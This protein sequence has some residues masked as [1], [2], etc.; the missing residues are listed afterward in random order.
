ML[1]KI[2]DFKKH[3]KEIYDSW[4]GVV[5]ETTRKNRK[6][7]S[8]TIIL[9]PPNITGFLH[10]G[11]AFTSTIQDILLR[12]NRQNGCSTLG[13]PGIDHAGI[14]TQIVVEKQLSKNNISRAELGR[15]A[16]IKKIWEWKKESGGEIVNQLKRLGLSV[17]WDILKFTMDDHSC[18]AVLKAFVTLYKDGLIYRA[19]KIVNWDTSIK[20]AIS[21]LEVVNK[22]T[23]STLWFIKYQLSN[24]NSHITIATTRPETLFG[25]VAVAVHPGDER[26]QSL[27]GQSILI[28]ILNKEIP[29]IADEYC[30]PEKGTGAVKITPAHDFND[31]E[32]GKRNNLPV[33]NI[34]NKDGTLNEN[35]PE[36]FRGLKCLE[37]R[38]VLLEDLFGKELIEKTEEIT[39]SIP[40]N[41]RS[42]V[43]IEPLVTDQ[44]FLDAKKLAGPAIE[45]VK[46][47][48]I[49]FIP[50]HW[51]ATYFEWLEN[52]QPWCISRQIWWG[53]QIPVWYADDDMF[54]VAETEEEAMFL[55]S[56]HFGLPID[57]LPKL[58]RDQD[59]LDTWF[60]SGLW[61]F[62]TQGWPDQNGE[63]VGN[64][65]SDVLV[66]AFDI[67]FFWV[68]RMIMLGIYFMKEVPFRNVYIHPL[69]RDEKGKKM[70]KSKG[71]VID[72][73]TLIDK[74][75][76]DALRFTLAFLATPSSDI[77]LSEALVENGRNFITKIFNAA[78]FLEINECFPKYLNVA[79]DFSESFNQLLKTDLIKLDLNK[80]IINQ[81]NLFKA[82]VA[83]SIKDFRFDLASQDVLKFLKEVFCDV[84]IECMKP[85][86][87]T[88]IPKDD[89][90]E[91]KQTALYIFT[92][93]LKTSHS[94]IPFITEYLFDYFLDIKD[95]KDFCILTQWEDENYHVVE[96][97]SDI[98]IK[99]ADEIRSLRGLLGVLPSTKLD[100][101]AGPNSKDFFENNRHW[102]CF[103]AKVKNIEF[104]DAFEDCKGILISVKEN[105]FCLQYPE[106]IDISEIKAILEKK[107]AALNDDLFKLKQKIE[108]I[109]YKKAKPEKW[110]ADLETLE[111]KESELKKMLNIK[112]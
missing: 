9:P 2:F 112:F 24:S 108:N 93:F 1:D 75:G 107:I 89:V 32:V 30:N 88:N 55:A 6:D 80:W 76:T 64:Y 86:L 45:A 4:N 21:D 78:K 109:A 38:E 50:E 102:F 28:P 48:K 44:W 8:F 68:A 70:S 42:G 98:Y 16:F 97:K 3:E 65:P 82:N 40:Y 69:I 66:T 34:M 33:I 36:K 23:K 60:S 85:C 90:I 18:K 100:L 10:I 58:T 31:F 56:K 77:R 15:E 105:S 62:S 46:S 57:K 73:L 83:N 99:L 92:E 7:K 53:H 11:H 22:E 5:K 111:L 19:K 51:N 103:I 106:N 96:Q 91:T 74:Y 94:I 27:I 14:A 59:V 12:F 110:A 71:N 87:D 39:N 47:G 63:L 17:N 26:Y 29:I 84:Y 20:T 41:E 54:F 61:P 37:A 81:L 25:D 95:E 101:C 49:K 104:V 13:Q 43:V 67:I 72:P 35:V 79:D 52:I